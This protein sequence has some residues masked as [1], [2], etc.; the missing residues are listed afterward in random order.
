MALNPL[1]SG[2]FDNLFL[3]SYACLRE[4]DNATPT[5]GVLLC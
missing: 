4:G 1:G 5:V 3:G 2:I